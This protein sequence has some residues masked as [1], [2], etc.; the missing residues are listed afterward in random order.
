MLKTLG[1]RTKKGRK[2]RRRESTHEG[3]GSEEQGPGSNPTPRRG[4]RPE[5]MK[6]GRRSLVLCESEDDK[7]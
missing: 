5:W 4:M 7:P 2:W 3:R 6:A 1:R